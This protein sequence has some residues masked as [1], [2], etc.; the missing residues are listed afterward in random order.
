MHKENVNTLDPA[1]TI[2]RLCSVIRF[3]AHFPT[4]LLPCR[5]KTA[6]EC[7]DRPASPPVLLSA[8]AITTNSTAA[9]SNSIWWDDQSNGA[10]AWFPLKLPFATGA[11][12]KHI[13]LPS[14]TC[15]APIGC[16]G[17]GET[18]NRSPP[19]LPPQLI[20][21]TASTLAVSPLASIL[22]KA[23]IWGALV[24]GVD[25]Q[26]VFA[27]KPSLKPSHCQHFKSGGCW[28]SAAGPHFKG[29]RAAWASN[30]HKLESE[31]IA[32]PA[33]RVAAYLGCNTCCKQAKWGESCRIPSGVMIRGK[34]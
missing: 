22:L 34:C 4:K 1:V 25:E 6:L 30:L 13:F 10:F 2:T 8:T 17:I 27:A 12:L 23:L 5:P 33:D 31:W 11:H 32:G 15:T 29:I 20:G 16:I 7:A 28:R 18:H 21:G 24:P 19:P 14:G 26:I 3:L 9:C